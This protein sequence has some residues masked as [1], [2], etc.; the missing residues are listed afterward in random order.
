MDKAVRLKNKNTPGTPL[1]TSQLDRCLVLPALADSHLLKVAHDCSISFPSL[2]VPSSEILSLVRANELAQADLA[3]AAAE[4][5][6]QA[7]KK[8]KDLVEAIPPNGNT[9]VGES[10]ATPN[11]PSV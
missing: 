2:S 9:A 6:V 3:A 5:K 10:S 4:M 1:A 8:K 7:N 11:A